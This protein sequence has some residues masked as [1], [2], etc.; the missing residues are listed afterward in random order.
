M[1]STIAFGE[2]FTSA[3]TYEYI[4]AL[5]PKGQEGLFLG[6][7][8]LPVAI[9]AIVGGPVG[10]LIFNEIMC[11][12]STVLHGEGVENLLEL[13]PFWNSLGWITLMSVGF[14]SALSMWM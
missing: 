12:N 2:L 8:N 11:H 10:A 9:G 7:A 13:D 3:R 1:L 4:G 6:Y 5:A 14:L